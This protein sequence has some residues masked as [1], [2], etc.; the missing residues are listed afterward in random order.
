MVAF[1]LSSKI[2]NVAP[3]I[4]SKPTLPM[5][6]PKP[7]LRALTTASPSMPAASPATMATKINTKK[8]LNLYFE[9]NK[10]INKILIMSKKVVKIIF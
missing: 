1:D 4:T 10:I 9:L 7:V 6:S 2:P 5:V 3:K 8:V